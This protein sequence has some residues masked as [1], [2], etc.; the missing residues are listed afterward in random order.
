MNLSLHPDS[1]KLP[2]KVKDIM[3]G[4]SRIWY[5]TLWDT[6]AGGHDDDCSLVNPDN[7]YG[8]L[9]DHLGSQRFFKLTVLLI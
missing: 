2:Y 4:K 3:S 6:H 9:I 8:Y 7:G 1:N 5:N